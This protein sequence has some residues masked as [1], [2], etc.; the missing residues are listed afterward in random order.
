M[1][2][3]FIAESK[4]RVLYV[5][6]AVVDKIEYC[7]IAQRGRGTEGLRGIK[8]NN[9]ETIRVDTMKQGF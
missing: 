2:F 3:R 5:S 8:G 6:I 1:G 4:V 7:V 9:L